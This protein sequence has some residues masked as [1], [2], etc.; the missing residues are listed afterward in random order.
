MKT[1]SSP[2]PEGSNEVRAVDVIR[3]RKAAFRET[4]DENNL[5]N[6]MVMEDLAR[7]CRAGQT[8]FHADARIDALLQGRKEV[9]LRIA[10]HLGLDETELVDLFMKGKR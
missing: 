2:A 1:I 4:F 5:S 8:T 6:Q 9:W 7:F 10:N 3:R